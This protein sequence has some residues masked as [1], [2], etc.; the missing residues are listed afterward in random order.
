MLK[1]EEYISEKLYKDFNISFKVEEVILQIKDGIQDLCIIKNN[2]F[3]KV[4][5]LD[6]VTQITSKDEF[7]YHEMMSHVPLFTLAN[8]ENI[9]IIGGGDGG[10]AREVLKHKNI[11]KCTLVEIDENVV[12]FSKKH[13]PEISDGAF[14]N[15]KLDVI[16]TDGAKFV[17]NTKQTFDVIIVDSTDPHGP[18]QVLFTKQFYQN[19]HNI[20]K[21]DGILI[22]QNGVPFLQPEELVNSVKFFKEIFKFGTCI[23]ATIPTYIGGP[24]AM[25]FATNSSDNLNISIEELKRKFAR[26]NIGDLKYYNPEVHLASFA[27]PN[28]IKKLV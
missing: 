14:N 28:Y 7:I 22:T 16:I 20:L 27:L 3:G 10:I 17:E 15:P 23:T 26:S 19:C 11:K 9:L 1:P 5:M 4:M 18:G 12:S 13:L 6:N 25:G 21:K 8:A 24:M 2:C